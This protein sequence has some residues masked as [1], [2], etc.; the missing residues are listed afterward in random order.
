VACRSGRLVTLDA[1]SFQVTRTLQLES[2][3]R[4]VL[5]LGSELVVTRFRSA[6]VLVVAGDGTLAQRVTLSSAATGDT[7]LAYRAAVSVDGAV[8]VAHQS[9][10]AVYYTSGSALAGRYTEVQVHPAQANASAA[11]T[12]LAGVSINFG[13]AE[14]AGPLDLAVDAVSRRVA[15]LNT[16]SSLTNQT[17]P[18]L[19][20]YALGGGGRTA[21]ELVAGFPVAVAFDTNGHWLTQSREP[22]QLQLEDGTL[23]PLSSESHADTGVALFHAD[24]GGGVSCASCHPEAGD[25]GHVW[26]VTLDGRLT[27]RRTQALEGGVLGRAPFHWAGELKDMAELVHDAATRGGS[28]PF[29]PSP[30][31]VEALADWLDRVPKAAPADDIDLKLAA[32]GDTLFHDRDVGCSGC[33]AGAQLTDNLLHDVGTG[34]SLMTPTL[35]GVGL[36]EPLFHDGCV[37]RLQLPFGACAG[38][39]EHRRIAELSRAEQDALQA[40]LRTL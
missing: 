25:D 16:S 13:S 22:A 21:F 20:T 31:Q 18:A 23:I 39:T 30:A 35:L 9:V 7:T 11:G 8:Y 3:L 27:R 4:D 6:E 26:N 40:Y 36:R 2:D 29:L 37:A 14:R 17:L 12:P 28:P 1:S 10:G 5:Q 32:V 34:E 24:L 19:A 15:V 38:G 33:H